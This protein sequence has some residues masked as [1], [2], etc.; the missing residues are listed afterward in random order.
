[1]KRPELAIAMCVM[2]WASGSRLGAAE[3]GKDVGAAIREGLAQY[4][5][6]RASEAIQSLQKAID[7][8]QQ[9]QQAGVEG[10]LPKALAGWKAGELEREQFAAGT[11]ETQTSFFKVSRPF[12]REKDDA[13]LEVSLI[14]SPQYIMPQKEI[15]KVW[16]GNPM[17]L[18]ALNQDENART[19]FVERDGW[20]GWTR[21]DKG[22]PES[23]LI[24]IGEGWL[25]EV[26]VGI[27]DAGLL[28]QALAGVN[29][30]GIAGTAK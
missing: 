24:L 13:R 2:V 16:K 29:L 9:G 8:I 3:V 4:E 22:A 17:I 10:F 23:Q 15:L 26:R 21:V 1:M 18:Q 25:L 19:A 11:G 27:A 30:K 14:N 12:T 5:K 20:A 6:G 7:L 28:D